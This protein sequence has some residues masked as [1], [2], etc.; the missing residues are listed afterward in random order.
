MDK[1]LKYTHMG[2]IHGYNY[3][4]GTIYTYWVEY[5]QHGFE[6]IRTIFVSNHRRLIMMLSHKRSCKE[7]ILMS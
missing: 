5:I 4:Y 6:F 2:I 7:R 3:V 1:I